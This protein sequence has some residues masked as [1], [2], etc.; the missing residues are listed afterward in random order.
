MS[1]YFPLK[2]L[3]PLLASLKLMFE[4]VMEQIKVDYEIQ[5]TVNKTN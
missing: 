4:N 1:H 2:P 5:Y 3:A